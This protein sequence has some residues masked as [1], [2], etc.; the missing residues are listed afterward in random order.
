MTRPL[1]SRSFTGAA[2]VAAA[3]VL[4]VSASGASARE[5]RRDGAD[6][7]R[8]F[9][10]TVAAVYT[11][12]QAE[13]GKEVF[14][15]VCSECHEMEDLTNEDFRENWDGTTLYEL[16]DNIR[17]TMPD[18]NPGTLTQEQYRDVTAY[19]LQLNK[20]PAGEQEFAGDSASASAVRLPLKALAAAPPAAD[21]TEAATADSSTPPDSAAAAGRR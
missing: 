21:T 13:R 4:I 11:A 16:F 9:A 19:L 6:V 18:E 14:T 12:P 15:A 2:A 20:L 8:A 5:A 3:A 17:T 1:M 7:P 10:D